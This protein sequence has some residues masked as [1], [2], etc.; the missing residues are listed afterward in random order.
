MHNNVCVLVLPVCECVSSTTAESALVRPSPADRGFRLPTD[1]TAESNTVTPVTHHLTQGDNE[2]WGNCCQQFR[3]LQSFGC[4][5]M[6][7]ELIL[8][9]QRDFQERKNNIL[10]YH[11]KCSWDSKAEKEKKDVGFV[12]PWNDLSNDYIMNH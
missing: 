12:K 9:I 11:H 5:I 1:L 8:Y 6:T 4:F 7:H 2:L 10:I 3:N